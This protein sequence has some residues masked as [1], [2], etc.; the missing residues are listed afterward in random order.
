[1]LYGVGTF[2]LCGDT[3]L[4]PIGK[5]DE[6]QV[7]ETNVAEA[8]EDPIVPKIDCLIDAMRKGDSEE[9]LQLIG[10]IEDKDIDRRGRFFV[11]SIFLNKNYKIK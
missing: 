8:N 9:A 4:R 2:L 5:D 3:D 7:V 11:E 10:G 1:M 6:A